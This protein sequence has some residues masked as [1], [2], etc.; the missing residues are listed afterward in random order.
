M[1]E[2]RLYQVL[3][4]PHVSEKSA[5]DADSNNAHTFR[6]AIDAN[7]LE[8]KN[9]VEKLFSVKVA[10]VRI[11]KVKGKNKRFGAIFGRRSD[12]KKAIVRL[13]AG[14]DIDLAGTGG[15]A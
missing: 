15:A 12:W 3:L 5:V 1:N 11:V 8:V 7:K 9:A 2:E 14:H 13:Q 10:S 6:V 4:S